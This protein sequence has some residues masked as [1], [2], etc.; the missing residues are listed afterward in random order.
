MHFNNI[1]VILLK[2]FKTKYLKEIIVFQ[3]LFL[4]RI[5]TFCQFKIETRQFLQ[6]GNNNNIH[7]FCTVCALINY[8][9]YIKLHKQTY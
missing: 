7:N 5:K 4:N 8:S 6:V 2:R 9:E 1:T 3:T